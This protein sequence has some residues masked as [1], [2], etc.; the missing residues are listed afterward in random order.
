MPTAPPTLRGELEDSPDAPA[1]RPAYGHPDLGRQ[2]ICPPRNADPT[3]FGRADELVLPMPGTGLVPCP[4]TP[5]GPTD[6]ARSLQEHRRLLDQATHPQ[7]PDRLQAPADPDRRTR[8]RWIVG[9][10]VAFGVWRLLADKLQALLDG[11]T[12]RPRL[13]HEAARLY[14]TYS[15]LLLYAGSCS[16]RRYAATVRADMA[17]RDPAFS[18]QWTRDHAPLLELQRQVRR[19]FPAPSVSPLTRA[20]RLNHHVHM[21]VAELLVP[22]G[23]SLLQQTGR[24]PAQKPTEAERNLSD[25]YFRVRRRPLCHDG[26]AAQIV[27]RIAQIRCDIAAHGLNHENANAAPQPP[28]IRRLHDE[29]TELLLHLAD[30]ASENTG[31]PIRPSPSPQTL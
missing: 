6:C 29:A 26:F 18:G 8:H 20:A 23:V 11:P 2:V 12:P 4:S 24:D 13:V 21:T 10:Q 17:V 5:Y 7:P 15:I 25:D 1:V 30:T 28:A 31:H 27:L 9:H 3:A 16:A 19:A 14:D 22:D